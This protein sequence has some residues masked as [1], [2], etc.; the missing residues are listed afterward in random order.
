[1]VGERAARPVRSVDVKS[2]I[3]RQV[4]LTLPFVAACGGDHSPTQPSRTV[5]VTSVTPSTGS[6]LG[7]MHLTVTGGPFAA[8]A[9]VTLVGVEQ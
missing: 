7:G 9:T 8:D 1:V 3:R 5:A 6:T 4:A 2:L